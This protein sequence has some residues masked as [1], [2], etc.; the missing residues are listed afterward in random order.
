M[1]A[2]IFDIDGTLTN[3]TKVDDKC[4][5]QAFENV[6]GIDISNQDWSELKHVTE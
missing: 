6:F 1:T 4:F 5:I 3:T 2:T